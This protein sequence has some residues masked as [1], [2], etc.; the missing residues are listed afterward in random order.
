MQMG[1]AETLKQLNATPEK[2]L[3]F[4]LGAIPSS[5]MDGTITFEQAALVAYYTSLTFTEI[6]EKTEQSFKQKAA[7]TLLQYFAKVCPQLS[8]KDVKLL[9]EKILIWQKENI[10]NDIPK[11]AIVCN[12]GMSDNKL[13]VTGEDSKK[14][15]LVDIGEKDCVQ[16]FL[17]SVGALY[18][19]GIDV[20]LDSLY[21]KVEF[22]VSRGTPGIS[23][24]L[25][26]N[27]E[28]DWYVMNYKEFVGHDKGYKK[29]ELTTKD[30]EWSYLTGHVIDGRLYLRW[31][32]LC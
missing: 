14:I 4:S 22:P 5:Y 30:E 3:G 19:S 7:Q 21:P 16:T 31:S 32:R 12:I 10:E 17:E 11:S 13:R 20:V 25:K 6:F 26:W 24:H 15:N 28:N 9:I 1:L 8:N 29:M 23:S 2:S 27:H 18:Q